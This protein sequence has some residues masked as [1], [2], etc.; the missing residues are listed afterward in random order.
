MTYIEVP[1]IFLFGIVELV[2]IV[3]KL[4]LVV[5]SAWI[6]SDTIP[7]ASEYFFFWWPK[8]LSIVLEYL[9]AV[10]CLWFGKTN[11]KLTTSTLYRK[12]ISIGWVGAWEWEVWLCTQPCW[13]EPSSTQIWV[14]IFL[15]M[16]MINNNEKCLF[17][18]GW[19]L[20]LLHV[21]LLANTLTV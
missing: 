19:Y 8:H 6:W 12:C 2:D 3:G 15:L 17:L 14:F 1:L 9:V 13:F 18:L 21:F 20:F 11:I 10:W 7:Q 16:I 5:T 4:Y